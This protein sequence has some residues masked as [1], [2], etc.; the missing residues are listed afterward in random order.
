MRC[1]IV[2]LGA[3]ERVLDLGYDELRFEMI[4]VSQFRSMMPKRT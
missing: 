3:V 2:P 4:A 1:V